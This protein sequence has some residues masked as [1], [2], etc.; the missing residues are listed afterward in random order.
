MIGTASPFGLLCALVS[1]GLSGRPLELDL[2]EAID[3]SRVDW[4]RLVR[5][6]GTHLLTPA[7]AGPL[8]DPS[9]DGTVPEDLRDYLAALHAAAAERNQTLRQEMLE[10]AASLNAIG[11]V[12]VLLKGGIRLVD[13]LWPDPAWRFMNDLDL[14]V[15]DADLWPCVA[16]LA[17]SGWRPCDERRQD[18][19]QH[20]ILGHPEATVRLELH[21]LPVAAERAELLPA[22]R[23]LN[24]ARPVAIDEAMVAIPAREDQIVHLVA[25]GMLEHAF[26]RNGRCVLRELVELKLLLAAADPREIERARDRFA[27]SGQQLAWDVSLELCARCLG[28]PP[29]AGTLAARL[30]VA[31]A[32]LQQRSA[33]AMLLLGPLGWAAARLAARPAEEDG[34]SAPRRLAGRFKMF[35][36]KTMW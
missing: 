12:P 36:R 30:L 27:T 20:V 11:V 26:L 23:M 32:L 31:R 2:V 9:L 7:L 1:A 16:Q 25:H 3:W 4:R 15:P 22:A 14:L 34:W 28:R 35:Y 8:A 33:L 29:A 17:R 18:L 5:L 6:S 21:R 10:I 19:S 13:G 24:R